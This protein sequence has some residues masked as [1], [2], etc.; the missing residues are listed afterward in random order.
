MKKM[1]DGI[2]V[3]FGSVVEA[4]QGA[5]DIQNDVTIRNNAEAKDHK[6]LLRMGVCVGDVI[7]EG[8]D[9]DLS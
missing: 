1:G 6:M 3:E 4:V 9:V 8:D 5:T 7:V 2:L